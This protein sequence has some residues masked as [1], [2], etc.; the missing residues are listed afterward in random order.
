M[1]WKIV[2][3]YQLIW[4]TKQYQNDMENHGSQQH[5]TIIIKGRASLPSCTSCSP[6]RGA[7]VW[8]GAVIQPMIFVGESLWQ[9]AV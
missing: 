2:N 9:F 8:Y 7:M 4:K 5:Q 1:I 3:P 6:R